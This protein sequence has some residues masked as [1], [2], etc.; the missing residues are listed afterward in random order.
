M[1]NEEIEYDIESINDTIDSSLTF[2]LH[3]QGIDSIADIKLP[4]SD[5]DMQKMNALLDCLKNEFHLHLPYIT[6]NIQSINGTTLFEEEELSTL[7]K[8]RAGPNLKEDRSVYVSE[9][10]FQWLTDKGY[11]ENDSMLDPEEIL[12]FPIEKEAQL[13][14]ASTRNYYY[15]GLIKQ[16]PELDEPAPLKGTEYNLQ[17]YKLFQEY[18]EE[19]KPIQGSEIR[20]AIDIFTSLFLNSLNNAKSSLNEVDEDTKK[21]CMQ[22]LTRALRNI[23][24]HTFPDSSNWDKTNK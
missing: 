1:S 5:E 11:C 13:V 21:K 8:G 23:F 15:S 2:D 24:S 10:Y 4:S 9:E 16:M 20:K 19:I 22:K 14:D 17:T 12:I 3:L 7:F 6:S 18:V